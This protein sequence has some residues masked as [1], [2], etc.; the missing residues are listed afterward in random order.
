MTHKEKKPNHGKSEA[1]IPELR[2]LMEKNRNE[3]KGK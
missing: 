1:G 2:L 3:K